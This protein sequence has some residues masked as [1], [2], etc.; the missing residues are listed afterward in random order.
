ML[1]QHYMKKSTEIVSNPQYMTLIEEHN[2][3]LK[4]EGYIAEDDDSIRK[5]IYEKDPKS[6]GHHENKHEGI[7]YFTLDE[8]TLQKSNTIKEFEDIHPIENNE[9]VESNLNHT[10]QNGNPFL[11]RLKNKSTYHSHKTV[12]FFK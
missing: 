1:V 10:N 7:I 6:N 9:N 4:T 2:K 3:L 5:R 11:K 12:C 8:R